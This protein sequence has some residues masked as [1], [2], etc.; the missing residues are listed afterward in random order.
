MF[1]RLLLLAFFSY[2]ITALP[3]PRGVESQS[4]VQVAAVTDSASY[5]VALK[6]NTVDPNA[7]GEW[8]NTVLANGGHRRRDVAT[9]AGSDLRLKWNETIFNGLAGTFS[10]AEI[11]TLGGLDEVKYVQADLILHTTATVTQSNAPWGISR[12]SRGGNPLPDG[13]DPAALNFM[14]NFDDSGGRG[15]DI[16][17]LDTGVRTTHQ[18]YGGRAQ[19]LATFGPGTPGVDLNGHGSHVSGTAAG[20]VFGIAKNANIIGI[21][22]MG[23][24]GAG[25]TSDIVSAINLAANT[26]VTTG[27]PSVVSMSIGG[28]ANQAID[29]AVTNAVDALN[30]PFVVAAGNNGADASTTSPAR[31][32]GPGGNS[33][34]I[35]VGATTI[36]D[37][38]ATFS[39]FGN[40][41]DV[42]A[43][44]QDVLSCGID[45][46]SAV[47]SRSG[48]SMSTPHVSGLAA[49]IMGQEGKISPAALKQKLVGLSALGVVSGIPSGTT[50]TLVNNDPALV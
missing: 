46:D 11:E 4:S 23:D 24:D 10:Q 29:D 50:N 6:P 20:S 26:A 16:Y 21:K 18:E 43:P 8:L 28:S 36:T 34:V 48:T 42:L 25:A 7:R 40:N 9:T 5:I 27:R 49:L 17:V 12:V 35:T 22:C 33:G 2:P 3:T 14:Y 19:F 39:N 31:L 38:F 32:G 15:V 47:Q 30:I 13:S 37:A 41:V 45:S 1:E 44:G